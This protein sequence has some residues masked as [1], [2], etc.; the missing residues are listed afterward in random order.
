MWRTDFMDNKPIIRH[1]RNCK[2]SNTQKSCTGLSIY[3]EVRYSEVFDDF[4]RAT[5]LFCRHYKKRVKE[6]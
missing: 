1:C 5:A 2:W 6:E 3:C 4:Q